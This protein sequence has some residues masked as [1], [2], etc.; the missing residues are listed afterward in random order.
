MNM[1]LATNGILA[2]P[3]AAQS[4]DL[5]A[6]TIGCRVSKHWRSGRVIAVFA[7]C[8]YVT[9]D[10]GGLIAVLTKDAGNVAHGI[11]LDGRPRLDTRLQVGLHARLDSNRISFPGKNVTVDLSG[12]KVW[13]PIVQSGMVDRL[14]P[15]LRSFARTRELLIQQ[16]AGSDSEF[17][18]LV[19]QIGVPPTPLADLIKARLPALALALRARDSTSALGIIGSFIGLGPGLTP[20]GDDFV[21]GFLAGLAL[22]AATAEARRFLQ[23]MREGVAALRRATTTVSAQH[24][25]DACHLCFSEHLSNLCVAIGG[26]Q[27]DADLQSLV[28]A[29]LSIGATSGADAAAGLIFALSDVA[30]GD[31]R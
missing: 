26:G 25:D 8:C 31:G 6:D 9:T 13:R 5:W 4:Y 16:A 15:A 27:P 21:V 17:L 14:A 11:R 18:K 10:D 7:R 3:G 29:Q 20:A 2:R 12:A 24:L 23:D 30:P 28:A 22:S 1:Q 19:L